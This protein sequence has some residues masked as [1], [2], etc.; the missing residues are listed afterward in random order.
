MIEAD[1]V[2]LPRHSLRGLSWLY[3]DI[4]YVS[5][6]P[7]VRVPTPVQIDIVRSAHLT[8]DS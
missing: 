4:V 1:W 3:Q 6:L 8:T 7:M 5:Q 2:D